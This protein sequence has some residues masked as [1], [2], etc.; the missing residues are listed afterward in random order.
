MAGRQGTALQ[1]PAAARARHRPGKTAAGVL[2]QVG[3]PPRR[4][5]PVDV[6]AFMTAQRSGGQGRLQVAGA[7]GGGWRAA[8]RTLRRRL[9]SVSG[10][11]RQVCADSLVAVAASNIRQ[12]TDVSA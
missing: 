8:A 4:V 6:L 1:A 11:H 3:K 9:S 12:L 5:R 7:G 2:P 10:L